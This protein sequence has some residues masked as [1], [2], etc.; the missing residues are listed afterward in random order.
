[1]MTRLLRVGALGIVLAFSAEAR[2]EVVR[3]AV[4]RAPALAVTGRALEVRTALDAPGEAVGAAFRV[5]QVGP[6]VSDGERLAPRLWVED[7]SG[8]PL[9]VGGL[10][11]V[12]PLEVIAT[13]DSLLAVDLVDLESY[14]ASVVGAEM[15]PGWPR[16][17]LE[18]QAIA[19]RTY[20]LKKISET[21][22]EAE[23]HVESTVLHQVYKGR[24][25][26]DPR[27]RAA[28]EATRGVVVQWEGK[29][30]DTFFFAHCAGRTETADDAFGR[31]A[32]YLRS[33]ACRGVEGAAGL[34]WT[35]RMPL[36]QVSARLRSAG[37]IGDE[38]TDVQ[39]VSHTKGGRAASARLVTE[40]GKR[41]IP[42]PE[43]RRLLGFRE[44]PS[45]DFTVRREKGELVFRGQGAGHGVGLCQWCAR[46]MAAG[47][48][49]SRGILAHFYPGTVLAQVD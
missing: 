3:V 46:G 26:S 18:A 4:Q 30:A 40:H 23:F 37:T 42:A 14:V 35:R 38:L 43:L 12:G 49:E 13:A 2:A 32:P 25:S 39:V 24:A 44:L 28:A 16:A 27:T 8:E 36:A 48:T 33:V 19:A 5:E 6:F 31:G 29:L 20:V 11:L 10:E 41:T 9:R 22:A 45:L 21:K 34:D 7:A 15:P 1:M 17:A 47:G